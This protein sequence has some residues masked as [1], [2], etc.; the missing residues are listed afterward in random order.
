MTQGTPQEIR[1]SWAFVMLVFGV[2]FTLWGVVVVARGGSPVL[3]A[4][5][6]VLLVGG[7][8]LRR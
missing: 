5:G 6:V 7:F 2:L 1:R 3:V 4:I 8:A